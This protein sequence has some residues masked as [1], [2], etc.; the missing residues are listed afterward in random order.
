MP[1]THG[2][3]IFS[4]LLYFHTLLLCDGL[5]C[6]YVPWNFKSGGHCASLFH[7]LTYLQTKNNVK[8][9]GMFC[10]SLLLSVTILKK[11]ISVYFTVYKWDHSETCYPPEWHALPQHSY[12]AHAHVPQR[13]SHQTF[14]GRFNVLTVLCNTCG[15]SGHALRTFLFLLDKQA[16]SV[17]LPGGGKGQG[18]PD[19]TGHRLPRCQ[20]PAG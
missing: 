7:F 6:M 19:G 13:R 8:V 20:H 17:C 4:K 2:H 16:V 5:N 1:Q 14:G 11:Y 10:N 9:T 15:S 18:G 12:Q 3:H